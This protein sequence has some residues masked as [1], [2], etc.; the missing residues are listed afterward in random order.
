MDINTIR[1]MIRRSIRNQIKESIGR[2]SSPPQSF[3][4]FRRVFAVA[5]GETG[6]PELAVQVGD[7]DLHDGDIFRTVWNSWLALEHEL[8]STTSEEERLSTW[9]ELVPF[10]VHDCV[11]DMLGD[12]GDA[13]H[14][15]HVVDAMLRMVC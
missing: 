6:H 4:E 1:V 8:R 13:P 3:A 12:E 9:C 14:A 2:L 5:L 15:Q 11:V 7:L 10:Y